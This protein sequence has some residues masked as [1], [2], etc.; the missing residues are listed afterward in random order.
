MLFYL[1]KMQIDCINTF[2]WSLGS[3]GDKIIILLSSLHFQSSAVCLQI[4]D[5]YYLRFQDF[6]NSPALFTWLI[7]K[8]LSDKYPIDQQYWLFTFTNAGYDAS[9]WLTEKWQIISVKVSF[10]NGIHIVHNHYQTIAYSQGRFGK[11]FN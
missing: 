7:L 1:Y 4:A 3:P 2:I 8:I 9:R 6:N 10:M 5:E 11:H